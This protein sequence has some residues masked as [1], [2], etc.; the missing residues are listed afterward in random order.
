[1]RY[2][3]RH[4]FFPLVIILLTLLLGVFMLFSI[5]RENAR[6]TSV[7][8]TLTPVDPQT[9]R[10]SL[11][12]LITTFETNFAQ[13]RDDASRLFVAQQAFVDLLDLRVPPEDKQRHLELALLFTKI[14]TT[15]KSGDPDVEALVLE[16]QAIKEE[17]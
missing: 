16:L 7:E 5:D 10:D 8:E 11:L 1:M 12:S 6:P 4:S 2:Y 14:Q 9:Y 17:L 3:H 15:L 13:A